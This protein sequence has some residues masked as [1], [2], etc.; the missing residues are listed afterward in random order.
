[1]SRLTSVIDAGSVKA[2][3]TDDS[4][5]VVSAVIPLIPNRGR[6]PRTRP[7]DPIRAVARAL[8]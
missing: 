4:I 7:S 8:V 2:F 5:D 6:K 1:M 3:L